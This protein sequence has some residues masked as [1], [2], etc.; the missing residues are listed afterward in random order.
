MLKN[1]R[2]LLTRRNASWKRRA[3]VALVSCAI[4]ALAAVA[5]PLPTPSGGLTRAVTAADSSAL[6]DGT[7]TT[8]TVVPATHVAAEAPIAADPS[9]SECLTPNTSAT[10]WGLSY[11]QGVITTFD[12]ETDS[13]VTCI[14]AYLTGAQTWAQ[15]IQPWVTGSAEGYSSWVAE[16][17]QSRQLVLAMNLIPDD[18][19]D[20]NDPLK[21]ERSCVVGNFDSYATRL[22]NNLVASG[23]GN[24]V[25][26]LG[27]E[28]NGVWESDFIGTTTT[29]QRLWAKCF[30]NEVTGFRRAP[31]EHLLFDWNPNACVGNYP[32]AN[33]YPGNAYVDILGLD[34]YDVGCDEPNTPLSFSQLAGEPAG[35]TSFEAFAKAMGKPMSLPE[36]GL[37][38]APSGDDPGYIDG[39]GSTVANGDFAFETYFDGG[40]ENVKAMPLGTRTPLSL[41][42]YRAW[43]GDASDQ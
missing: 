41:A 17:P 23:L 29:E 18:L 16:E 24:S 40:G 38:I 3:V 36:W 37:S 7:T 30:A 31:G 26:R 42:A 13:T 4:G 28:M 9:R 25:I 6:A 34:L 5:G 15:W 35:L 10:E 2:R 8:T 27:D 43:F 21:W 32:F 22:A 14:S 39:I 20:V 12:T 11:L 33:Y 1:R 19:G